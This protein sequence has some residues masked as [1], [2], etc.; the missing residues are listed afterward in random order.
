MTPRTMRFRP[1]ALSSKTLAVHTPKSA[2]PAAIALAASTCGPAL[3]NL[4]IEAGVAI[5]PFLK[6]RVIS[7]ELKLV[8]PFEL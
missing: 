3:A 6:G 2:S 7:G 4:Y 1:W 5:E 8:L